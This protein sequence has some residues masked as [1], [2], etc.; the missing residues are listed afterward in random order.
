MREAEAKS[1]CLSNDTWTE[2][3]EYGGKD[4]TGRQRGIRS[5]NCPYDV[6]KQYV[7]GRLAM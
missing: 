3:E 4:L 6:S 5:S 7:K 1:E 2:A